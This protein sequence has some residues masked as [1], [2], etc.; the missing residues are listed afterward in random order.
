TLTVELF[1]TVATLSGSAIAGQAVQLASV[2]NHIGGTAH[3]T[4]GATPL[5]ATVTSGDFNLGQTAALSLGTGVS[6]FDIV[7]R[8]GTLFGG[9]NML[10]GGMGSTVR[11]DLSGNNF[12][13]EGA[14]IAILSFNGVA[15]TTLAAGTGVRIGDSAVN[16]SLEV[17][18]GADI[19]IVGAVSAHNG[20]G[21][22]ID[23]AVISLEAAGVVTEAGGGSL[24]APTL[25]GSAGG[26]VNLSGGNAVA[27]LAGFSAGGTFLFDD[28]A[29]TGGL[30]VSAAVG[31]GGNVTIAAAGTLTVG[32]G[33]SGAGVSLDATSGSILLGATVDARLSTALLVAS[34]SILDTRGGGTDVTAA[35]LSLSAGTGIGTAT[36]PIN[37]VVATVAAST[38]SGGINLLNTTAVDAT[39]TSLAAGSGD[40]RLIQQGGGSLFVASANAQNGGIVIDVTGGGSLTVTDAMTGNGG[41][42]VLGLDSPLDLTINGTVSA[43][44]SLTGRAE[45]DV[46]LDGAT[47][48]SIGGRTTL[49]VDDA[50]P[51]EPGIGPGSFHVAS[52]SVVT[53]P[54]NGLGIF[55]AR[56][57]QVEVPAGSLL[58]N[59]QSFSDTAQNTFVHFNTWYS[60]TLPF[61]GAAFTIFFKEGPPDLLPTGGELEIPFDQLLQIGRDF[62]IGF[63]MLYGQQN[64]KAPDAIAQASS[65]DML[66]DEFS[67]M[68]RP[69]YLD[70]ENPKT[71]LLGYEL[72]PEVYAQNVLA[73][74]STAAGGD[75]ISCKELNDILPLIQNPQ[76]QADYRTLC[77][78]RGQES[79]ATEPSGDAARSAGTPT[80]DR[81][82]VRAVQR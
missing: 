13:G 10:N 38:G 55:L 41:N 33:I 44:G 40:V 68:A 48:V 30:L 39:A 2:G 45:K 42:I 34:G 25:T 75:E 12:T 24:S 59:G 37:I 19:G 54:E 72:R 9:P 7:G 52:P 78:T 71:G 11:L 51:D 74:I 66:P 67:A 69:L 15:D 8:N 16:G 53:T 56:R 32:A 82:F 4:T 5:S 23:D 29:T 27:V 35:A 80:R 1:G 77:A 18:V 76:A 47:L 70:V 49:I 3:V 17:S 21:G 31:A 81:H 43:S 64:R 62:P 26:S 73:R 57:T 63:G 22:I 65:F 6:N 79:A 36:A 14:P 46:T 60:D 20:H 58:L 28:P 50:F 61:D